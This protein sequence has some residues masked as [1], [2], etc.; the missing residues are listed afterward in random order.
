MSL[1]EDK[2]SK[3]YKELVTEYR[4]IDMLMEPSKPEL[5]L[6]PSIDDFFKFDNSKDCLDIKVMDYQHH[7]KINFPLAQ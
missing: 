3:E 7:G 4:I 5:W 1:I 2:D 6:D